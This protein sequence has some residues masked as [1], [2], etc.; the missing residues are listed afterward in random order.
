MSIVL[1]LPM[2]AL[3]VV[4]RRSLRS[5]LIWSS[6]PSWTSNS[7]PGA[8][9]SRYGSPTNCEPWK[10]LAGPQEERAVGDRGAEVGLRCQHG[11]REV[12]QPRVRFRARDQGLVRVAVAWH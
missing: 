1:V 8:T 6:T 2:T 11:D 10:I 3:L 9:E 4:R 7:S 12:V 5:T